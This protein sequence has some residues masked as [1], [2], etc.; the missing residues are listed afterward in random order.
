MV[1]PEYFIKLI[2]RLVLRIYL[3]FKNADIYKNNTDN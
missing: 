3:L 1:S 2:E